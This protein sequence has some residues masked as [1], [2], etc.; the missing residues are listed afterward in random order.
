[1]IIL[2]LQMEKVKTED[3]RIRGSEDFLFEFEGF[4]YFTEIY[5]SGRDRIEVCKLKEKR[6][7]VHR[8]SMVIN[9][10]EFIEILKAYLGTVHENK[11][12][13]GS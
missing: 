1:M 9:N 11:H 2:Y 10:Q 3:E 12:S 5:I 7:G 6:L 13:N 8:K 4:L